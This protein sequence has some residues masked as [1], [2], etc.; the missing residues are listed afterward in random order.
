MFSFE[1][2]KG[3]SLGRT[4]AKEMERSR[5]SGKIVIQKDL[6]VR[7][8]LHMTE[9]MARL[10][11]ASLGSDV[12]WLQSQ[13]VMD[14]S[15]LLAVCKEDNVAA[16]YGGMMATEENYCTCCGSQVFFE[17]KKKIVAFLLEN[18]SSSR[19]P[20]PSCKL[21]VCV[22]CCNVERGL[23][24]CHLCAGFPTC[25][26]LGTN[27]KYVAPVSAPL[28]LPPRHASL[29]RARD[30]GM[31]ATSLTGDPIPEIYY[32]GLIDFLQPFNLRKNLEQQFKT[33]VLAKVRQPFTLFSIRYQKEKKKK[34][35]R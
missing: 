19:S 14:Y 2:K 27:P 17:K 15:F 7:R 22:Y 3:S 31:A 5:D 10:L 13:N 32:F 4:A 34:P 35:G 9:D 1:Q 30:G 18:Q 21:S 23:T 29:F 16:R 25:P 26:F 28:S 8:K 12:A 33:V 20:C 24:P 6:D 11:L